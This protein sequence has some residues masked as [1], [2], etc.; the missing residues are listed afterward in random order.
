LPF[1]DK[2][3]EASAKREKADRHNT[4]KRAG[5]LILFIRCPKT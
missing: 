3:K 5:F 1:D 4:M 2:E